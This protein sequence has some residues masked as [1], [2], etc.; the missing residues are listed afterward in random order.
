MSEPKLFNKDNEFDIKAREILQDIFAPV[1]VN[2]NTMLNNAQ[3]CYKFADI[4]IDKGLILF[5][6]VI[7]KILYREVLNKVIEQYNYIGTYS[8]YYFLLKLFYGNSA[9]IE[10]TTLA[11]AHLQI[12]V[13]NIDIRTYEWVDSSGNNMIDDLDGVLIFADKIL[14]LSEDNLKQLIDNIKP[15]GYIVDIVIND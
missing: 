1:L 4:I 15:A 7:P 6:N 10:F 12:N 11:P 2:A 14:D 8:A 9:I 5:T 13:S 3:N